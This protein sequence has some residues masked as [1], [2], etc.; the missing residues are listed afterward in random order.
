MAASS[1]LQAF[2]SAWDWASDGINYEIIPRIQSDPLVAY[3]LALITVLLMIICCM[4]VVTTNSKTLYLMDFAVFQP[5][6][7]IYKTTNEQLLNLA[8]ESFHYP[9]ESMK[10]M[11]RICEGTGLGPSTHIP[12]SLRDLDCT[13]KTAREEA[14]L[15]IFGAIDAL[16]EKT[17]IDPKDISGVVTNCSL[18]CPTPSFSAM[19]V[20][21]YGLSKNVRSF[22][23][24]GMGCSASIIGVDVI[25]AMMRDSPGLILLVSTE[26]MT[27]NFYRGEERSMLMQ[28]VL[29]RMG[30]SAV[31]FYNSPTYSIRGSKKGTN[32][33]YAKYKLVGLVR[34]HHG[35]SDDSYRCV[36]QSTDQKGNVGVIIN[37]S[38]PRCAG[39]ALH[40]NMRI[41]FRKFMPAME[42][43]RFVW[44]QAFKSHFWKLKGQTIDPFLPN[45]GR[46][47]NHLCFHT[48]GRG[49]LDEMEKLL[50]LNEQQMA[51]SRATLYRYGNT[52]SS[53]IW[54]ELA[55]HEC[56]SGVK[57]G[58]K[59]W[60]IAFGSG[61]KCN[62]AVWQAT[63]AYHMTIPTVFDKTNPDFSWE[64]AKKIPHMLSEYEKT[65]DYDTECARNIQND[66]EKDYKQFCNRF[67]NRIE[68][69][70]G[71]KACDVKEILSRTAA[72]TDTY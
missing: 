42:I 63:D 16:L 8:L 58:H 32:T 36:Y 62:S 11:R 47:F 72:M 10:F 34:T 52:S 50:H 46:I 28:N 68:Q 48:G 5:D 64:L 41:V 70:F 13:I 15:V 56:Q 67:K 25:K 22:S 53:S 40:D 39:K 7:E 33:L 60:Q 18:F 35:S 30:C 2:E 59:I 3:C 4:Y 44:H 9:A 31:L 19:I 65:R 26:N 43:C 45:V 29:F 66:D 51:A 23:L 24:G 61:F 1:W 57:P 14:E 12:R 20:N 27:Q 71:T 21:K 49:V 37:K 69:D 6:E 38:V 54:Y 55:Y 17:G